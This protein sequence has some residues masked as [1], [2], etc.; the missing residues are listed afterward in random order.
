M[1]PA[2]PVQMDLGIV[3]RACTLLIAVAAA[4]LAGAD[5]ARAQSSRSERTERIAIGL[6]TPKDGATIGDASG[7]AFIAGRAITREGKIENY[8]VMFVI[9]GSESTSNSSQADVNGDGTID[10]RS[11][12]G[13]PPGLGVLTELVGAC[14]LSPDSIL[15]VE[16][17][18]VRTL[19][20][21]L[22]PRTSQVGIVAFGGDG[23]PKT[24]D[25][26]VRASL[27]SD[28]AS[29]AKVLKQIED[30]G[31]SGQTNMQAGVRSAALELIGLQP[32][33][34]SAPRPGSQ[35]IILFLSD[36]LPTAP[37]LRS[38]QRNRQLAIEA[39]A[40]AG[41]SKIR[42]FT[43]GIGEEALSQP[44]TLVDMAR[45][46]KG[47]FTPILEA[48]D[49]QSVFEDVDFSKID[50]LRVT[51]KTNQKQAE[52][53]Q[54]NADGAFTSLVEMAPGAN[55]VEI[56]VRAED[57]SEAK[58]EITLNWNAGAPAPSLTPRLVAKRNRL[59]ENRLA[60]LRLR[61][62]GVKGPSDEAIRQ[63]LLKKI[64]EQR[65]K[66][67]ERAR[68]VRIEEMRDQGVSPQQPE[69]D[70]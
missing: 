11:C 20:K 34:T 2:A 8:D 4:G 36:G 40:R 61:Q 53:V 1:A 62:V 30:M 19:L 63:E 9:D 45:V 46:T 68:A 23:N 41:K 42:V 12:I 56:Y 3:R 22:D 24:E 60:D 55:Q 69:S 13:A 37:L 52:Y 26:V 44:E 29:L 28:F 49:L 47:V 6:E 59:L 31:P 54:R 38:I 64:A 10:E 16:L 58:R 25:A 14:K 15:S 43:Y 65:K 5:A 33:F 21:R 17:L 7:M 32:A 48:R 50:L 27:T 35:M 39:A 18:A 70:D 67:E 66:A 57:G 51:N